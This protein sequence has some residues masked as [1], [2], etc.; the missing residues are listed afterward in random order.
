[1]KHIND[2]IDFVRKGGYKAKITLID[3]FHQ[4]DLS[5]IYISHDIFI[6]IGYPE[7]FPRPP[8][9]ALLCEYVLV[10]FTGGGGSDCMYNGYPYKG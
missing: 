8:I 9:K 6:S 10:G 5:Q 4:T 2:I 3:R 1:V 7:G